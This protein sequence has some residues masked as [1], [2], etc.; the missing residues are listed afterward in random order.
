MVAVKSLSGKR[1]Y[2]DAN[3][4]IYTLESLAPWA[5]QSQALLRMVDEGACFGITSELTLA[6]CLVRPL[7]LKQFE[8]AK[9]YRQ[10]I[11][12][13]THMEATPIRRDIL[14]R[15]AEIRSVHNLKLPDAI[16]L[17]TAQISNCTALLT[18]DQQL[19]A[20]FGKEAI[21]VSELSL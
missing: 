4:F 13:S 18:N 16:H 17:A 21:L 11:Q 15:A 2:L 12:S 20:C 8:N 14:I 5:E 1:L 3:V 10:A 7:Q 6:E 19:A 9:L